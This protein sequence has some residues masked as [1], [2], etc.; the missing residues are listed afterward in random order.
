MEEVYEELLGIKELQVNQVIVSAQQI[1]VYGESK[2]AE[3][4]CPCCLKKCYFV[5]QTY[6]R[7]VRDLSISGKVV[8][9]YLTTRQ[10]VCKDCNR[11]FYEQFSFVDKKES[12]TI[13]YAQR[14]YD[15]CQ[16]IELQYVVVRENLCWQ[17][18]NRIFQAYASKQVSQS[19]AFEKARRIGMDEIA[20]KKG[21]QNYV[22]VVVDLDKGHIL[23]LL[24]DRSKAYLI[25]YFKGKGEAFCAQ[26]ELFC[27]D[28]WEGYLNAAKEVFPN[29]T[30]V[31]DR[32]HF[33]THL[34]KAVDNAR[35][36]LRRKYKDQPGLKNI[37]W[38]LLKNPQQLTQTEREQLQVLF[39]CPANSL[40]KASYEAKNEFRDILEQDLSKAQAEPKMQAWLEKI[41]ANRFMNDFVKFY[42]TWKNYILNYFEGRY[43]TGL[44]EG[45]N[46]KIK[47]IKRR[48][49]GFSNFDNFKARVQTAFCF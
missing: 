20:L 9:L 14:L 46:N 30:L 29:A 10:Y 43:T 39:A 5:K 49:F 42:T 38:L 15:L 33:F 45:I 35:K 2:L 1:E 12:V 8:Y 24:E 22:A 6:T 7:K 41:Q 19:K 3:A 28:M 4:H 13:R 17:T 11:H 44:I 32:F 48:A 34:Q 16:G 26:I 27:S 21:H 37:K 23:D 18:V 31:A 47:S 40:L 36:Y 25:K